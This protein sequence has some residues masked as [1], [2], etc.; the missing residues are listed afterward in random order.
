MPISP[1]TAN[2]AQQQLQDAYSKPPSNPHAGASGTDN[3]GGLL[4][5]ARNDGTLAIEAIKTDKP[6]FFDQLL[7]KTG[8]KA[9][10]PTVSQMELRLS[11]IKKMGVTLLHHPKPSVVKSYVLEV[12]S[13]LN[14]V[15][16]NAYEGHR[17]PEDLFDKVDIA[18]KKL[19]ELADD[20]LSSQKS[21]MHLLHSLGAL[22]GLLV[23]I[24]V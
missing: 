8:V 16:D 17:S 24:L 11:D 21:E 12:K 20:F 15:R 14:D 2:Y 23:D 7:T 22:Q 6:G 18:D 3:A 13:F 1:V 5:S 19:D 4:R 10:K 9:E